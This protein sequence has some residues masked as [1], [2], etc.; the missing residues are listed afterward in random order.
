MRGTT[1]DPA[2]D[3]TSRVLAALTLGLWILVVLGQGIGYLVEGD[4][5]ATLGLMTAAGGLG[6]AV[7]A[8]REVRS[9][10]PTATG[11]LW[12]LL[13]APVL[14]AI[15]TGS[16]GILVLGVPAA[17]LLAIEGIDGPVVPEGLGHQ[18]AVVLL[19]YLALAPLVDGLAAGA[20]EPAEMAVT[21]GPYEATGE[22]TVELADERGRLRVVQLSAE[23]LPDVDLVSGA[24]SQ[25]AEPAAVLERTFQNRSESTFVWP[26][27]PVVITEETTSA[28]VHEVSGGWSAVALGYEDR[29]TVPFF[30]SEHVEGRRQV[31]VV[32]DLGPEQ[33]A[34]LVPPFV[35]TVDRFAGYRFHDAGNNT[36]ALEAL[37]GNV[38]ADGHRL[39]PPVAELRELVAA[40]PYERHDTPVAGLAWLLAAAGSAM[41]VRRRWAG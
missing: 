4:R 3:S 35:E 9:S 8:F 1:I 19:A 25:D 28:Q 39:D 36:A 18:V 15:W 11:P 7:Y 16:W 5:A 12:A 26:F 29:T 21:D 17:V 30:L 27:P 37:A 2:D 31:I 13:L 33:R 22:R 23:D 32:E 40:G 6:L 24:L 41:L 34:H 20:S 14:W 10:G 38:T